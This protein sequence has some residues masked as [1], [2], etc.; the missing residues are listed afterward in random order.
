MTTQ[1][2]VNA[3]RTPLC[4]AAATALLIDVDRGI[5]P[6]CAYDGN[7]QPGSQSVDFLGRT[8]LAEVLQGDVW[9]T[10]RRQLADHKVPRGC[11][12]CISREKQTGWSQRVNMESRRSPNWDKGITFL[13]LD[14]SNLCNLQCRHC[15]SMYSSRWSNHDRKLGR[16]TN[17]IVMPD[18]E[19]LLENLRGVDLRWLDHVSIKGGEPMLNSDMLVLLQHLQEIGVFANIRVSMV[20]NGTV[21]NPEIFALLARVRELNVCL[22]IDGV[23]PVQS[24]IRHGG[25]ALTN[26]EK[27]IATYAEL[28]NVRF[29]RNT[30]VMA[31]NVFCLDRIDA[32]WASLSR[33]YPGKFGAPGYGLFVLHPA[34]LAVHCLQDSTRAALA[35]RY[36]ALDPK[37]YG[38]VIQVLEQP[39]A[40]AA[41]HDEFVRRTW[42]VD[43]ELGRSVLDSIPE[44]AAE[45]VL[46]QAPAVAPAAA[47]AAPAAA[48]LAPVAAPAGANKPASAPAA[49]SAGSVPTHVAIRVPPRATVQHHLQRLWQA[50]EVGDVAG[51]RTL[52]AESD[53]WSQNLSGDL[54]TACLHAHAAAHA[55]AGDLVHGLELADEAV[56]WDAGH[57]GVRFVRARILE[58]LGRT[59]EAMADAVR[60]QADPTLVGEA[61]KLLARCAAAGARANG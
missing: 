15:W 32:W 49:G 14:S 28:P 53:G 6:C 34:D 26:I 48:T 51:A 36:R 22:S 16:P 30:S 21:I 18:G 27:Q 10:V 11:A 43:Q 1:I 50:L 9:Q 13:E 41:R 20:T 12:D 56:T 57:P 8:P 39:F 25:S 5:R 46:L 55:L 38:P 61:G 47:G 44:L 31:Y 7:H 58:A 19:M 17:P 59:R 4:S 60:A 2:P 23:D 35:A 24:Y 45:M 37:L 52:V 54:R 33:R 40:G 3:R 29:S 42:R